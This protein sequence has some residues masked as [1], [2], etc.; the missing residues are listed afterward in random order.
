MKI[1]GLDTSSRYGSIALCDGARVLTEYNT[2]GVTNQT[3]RLMPTL[4]R[5]LADIGWKAGEIEGFV[6]VHGPGSFTGVRVGL[7]TVQGLAM[8]IGRPAVG[9]SSLHALA[10]GL[11]HCAIP[12]CP[13]L[14]ARKG[15]IYTALYAWREGRL[16]LL[17]PEQVVSPSLFLSRLDGPVMFLGD[18]VPVIEPLLSAHAR[19]APRFAAGTSGLPRASVIALWGREALAAASVDS[20][21]RLSPLYLRASEAELKLGKAVDTPVSHRYVPPQSRPDPS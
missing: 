4:E 17:E 3:E 13:V 2:L 7:A 5:M 1:L 12:L 6:V 16:E 18:G 15:E 14:D 8:A 19:M 20:A 21:A 9:I 11:P 10:L